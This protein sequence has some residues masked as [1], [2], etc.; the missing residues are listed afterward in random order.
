MHI[1]L[2]IAGS[3]IGLSTFVGQAAIAQ[4]SPASAPTSEESATESSDAADSAETENAEG[5]E[6]YTL[7]NIF[8]VEVPE[9]SI[10]EAVEAENYAVIT[11]EASDLKTEITFVNELPETYVSGQIDALIASGNFIDQYGIARVQGNEAFR[12]W[13]AELP[14]DF[15]RQVITFVGYDGIGTAKIVTHYNDPSEETKELIIHTHRSF[16]HISE[17]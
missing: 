8:S 9:G 12:L 11:T 7:P 6:T 14:G 5:F 17:E 2:W 13:L 10:A 15:S 4:T 3:I 1:R 16:E